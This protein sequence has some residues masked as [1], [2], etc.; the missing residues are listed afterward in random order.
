[1]AAKEARL[2]QNPKLKKRARY[3][4]PSPAKQPVSWRF[5]ETD[6]DGPFRWDAISDADLR[7]VVWIMAT[8]DHKLWS[9]VSGEGVGNIKG[10]PLS[11]LSQEALHRLRAIKKDDL[12]QLYEIR[13]GGKPRVWGIKRGD[14]FHVLWWDPEHKV[15]PSKMRHT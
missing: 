5:Y 14:A 13:V 8:I 11:R 1:M 7:V 6:N 3:E 2:S 9:S 15:C 12:D 4:Q 10:I